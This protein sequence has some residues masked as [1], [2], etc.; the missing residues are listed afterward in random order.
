MK[1]K[2]SNVF[3]NRNFQY[4]QHAAYN[5]NLMDKMG[6]PTRR[7]V[8]IFST[9]RA[10]SKKQLLTDDEIKQLWVAINSPSKKNE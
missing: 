5:L 1:E 7:N 9:E 3:D 8:G 10:H 6:S 4:S 2:E